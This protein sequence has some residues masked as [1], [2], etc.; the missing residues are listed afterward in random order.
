M[1]R[2][3]HHTA[4]ISPEP[5]LIARAQTGDSDAFAELYQTHK[6]R[7]YS[8]CLRMTN[9]TAEAE[10]LA[11]DA[12]LQVFRKISTFR[13]ESA[14]STWLHR[15]TVNTVLMHFRRKLPRHVSLD[16]PYTANGDGPTNAGD[17]RPMVR[18]YETRDLCLEASVTR[19]ALSR[20]IGELPEGYRTVFLLHDV[21]G[22]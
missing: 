19:V 16:E 4:T 10:E 6:R 2:E 9:N 7:I 18:D 11:Q 22:Y 20:A 5:D 17:G 3:S 13:G 12:F 15:L 21:E 8:L 1:N 14:F